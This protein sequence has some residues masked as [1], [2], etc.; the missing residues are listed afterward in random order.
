MLRR[1][2]PSCSLAHNRECP[3]IGASDDLLRAAGRRDRQ[4]FHP[5]ICSKSQMF[6]DTNKCSNVRCSFRFN[7]RHAPTWSIPWYTP[8]P[9]WLASLAHQRATSRY[10]LHE[11]S[12]RSKLSR[13][14]P[15]PPFASLPSVHSC[16]ALHITLPHVFTFPEALT[17]TPNGLATLA[18]SP[19]HLH[20]I[21]IW[22]SRAQPSHRP[23]HG[24]C[25]ASLQLFTIAIALDQ[26]S[27]ISSSSCA[28]V[29]GTAAGVGAGPADVGVIA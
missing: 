21:H 16:R 7:S 25:S 29:S 9:R 2:G 11:R 18:A 10:V 15:A 6:P 14:S 12:A 8:P 28:G 27:S 1:A 22:I 23:S 17:H 20:M 26:N 19:P 13:T 5:G 3:I 24:L 4:M